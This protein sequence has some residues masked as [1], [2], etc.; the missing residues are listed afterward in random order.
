MISIFERIELLLLCQSPGI[1]AAREQTFLSSVCLQK[2]REFWTHV[3][4]LLGFGL[5]SDRK[6]TTETE[7]RLRL[8][9]NTELRRIFGLTREEVANRTLE[10]LLIVDLND[11]DYSTNIIKVLKSRWLM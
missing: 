5:G 9:E 6:E 10:N 2:G 11:L 1:N 4:L 3:N 7:R 8:F